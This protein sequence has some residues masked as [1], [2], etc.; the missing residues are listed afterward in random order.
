M[1]T[2]AREVGEQADRIV[3]MRDG[4][5]VEDGLGQSTSQKPEEAI[6]SP[7]ADGG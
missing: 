7:Q 2:H 6:G 1:V 3:L 5:I 4:R